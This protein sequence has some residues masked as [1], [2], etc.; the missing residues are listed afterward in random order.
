M[1]IQFIWIGKSKDKEFT[2]LIE[3]YFKRLKYYS[4]AQITMLKE[5]KSKGRNV[6]ELKKQEALLILDQ[7]KSSDYLV[8][9]DERG[10]HKTSVELSEWIQ[11]KLNI[12]TSKLIIVIGGAYGAH[13]TLKDRADF[14]LSLSHLTLTHDMARIFIVEQVYRAF[15]ILRGEKYHNE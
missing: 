7:V 9:L 5:V 8:L 15:T 1:K 6:E 12:S 3:K 10:K 2:T 14:T 4:S 13:R 11:H